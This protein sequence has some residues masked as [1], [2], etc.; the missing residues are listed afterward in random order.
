MINKAFKEFNRKATFDSPTPFSLF[1]F[2]KG[3]YED[4]EGSMTL[5][6][7][8]MILSSVSRTK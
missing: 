1:V 8:T 2:L 3:C 5:P 4:F 7:T 6:A